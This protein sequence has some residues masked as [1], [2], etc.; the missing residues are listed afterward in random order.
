MS[1]LPNN[2]TCTLVELQF[3]LAPQ[4]TATGL[5]IDLKIKI[6]LI[7]FLNSDIFTTIN[8]QKDN[9][10]TAYTF[11]STNASFFSGAARILSML[12]VWLFVHFK[13]SSWFKFLAQHSGVLKVKCIFDSHIARSK[14]ELD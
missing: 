5:E 1:L 13:N 4:L 7:S 2:A 10:S 3:E 14:S 11:L 9:Y 12:F 8:L 6:Y